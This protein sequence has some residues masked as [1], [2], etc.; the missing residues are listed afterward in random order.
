MA[1]RVQSLHG[2]SLLRSPTHRAVR[3]ARLCPNHVKRFDAHRAGGG[4]GLDISGKTAVTSH[5]SGAPHSL[6]GQVRHRRWLG[7]KGP[8]I[9]SR[10]PKEVI[11]RSTHLT[12]R[13]TKIGSSTTRQQRRRFLPGVQRSG[14]ERRPER[15]SWQPLSERHRH[16]G[17][18]LVGRGPPKRRDRRP[19]AR[20]AGDRSAR[21]QCRSRAT[22]WSISLASAAALPSRCRSRTRSAKV[23]E[24][25]IRF[26]GLFE[27]VAAVRSPRTPRQRRAL[28]S[29]PANVRRCITRWRSTSWR[30]CSFRSP[31]SEGDVRTGEGADSLREV[32]FRGVH[33]DVGGGNGNRGL[34]WISL[35]LDVSRRGAA[36]GRAARP[37][38][39]REQSRWPR[40]AAADRRPQGRLAGRSGASSPTIASIP[41]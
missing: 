3:A 36:R 12:G 24:V 33:S 5:A 28:I 37:G 19:P 35:R 2:F 7:G 13:A 29:L 40:P 14:E 1:P 30:A 4:F 26:V 27:V 21:E 25:Q 41:A 22:T 16:Q 38:L 9:P 23:P 11:W 8:R 39:G 31:V 34:N 20:P 17:K 6:A 32:W 10:G 15:D 18:D